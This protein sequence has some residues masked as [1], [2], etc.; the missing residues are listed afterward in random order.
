MSSQLIQQSLSGATASQILVPNDLTVAG[1]EAVLGAL[2]VS[3]T[4]SGQDGLAMK[5]VLIPTGQT[6]TVNYTGQCISG[7]FQYEG[8][9]T[10]G[11]LNIQLP[12]DW[13]TN[14]DFYLGRMV[15]RTFGRQSNGLYVTVK[16]PAGSG[17]AD[18]QLTISNGANND[19]IMAYVVPVVPTGGVLLGNSM[20]VILYSQTGVNIVGG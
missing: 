12:T 9:G 2:T 6:V 14:H 5:T 20:G 10:A 8:S 13:F 15:L 19:V 18:Y 1:N 3:G 11:S 7:L 17:V 4:M 16:A